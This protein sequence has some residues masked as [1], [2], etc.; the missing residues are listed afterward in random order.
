MHSCLAGYLAANCPR[1]TTNGAETN[2]S[3]YAL[4]SVGLA[5]ISQPWIPGNVLHG[6]PLSRP[7]PGANAAATSGL[8]GFDPDPFVV[9]HQYAVDQRGQSNFQLVQGAVVQAPRTGEAVVMESPYGGFFCS[10]LGC[11]ATYLRVGDCRRHLKK[12]NGPFFPCTERGCPMEFY[13]HDKLRA[14]M[15]Q[16]HGITVPVPGNRRRQRGVAAH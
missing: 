6:R 11:N 14:H 10:E 7:L 1:H 16:G 13:R 12:H 9:E 4:A 15:K 2:S 5:T 8:S 3:A